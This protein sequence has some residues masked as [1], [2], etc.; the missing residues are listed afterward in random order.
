MFSIIAQAFVKVV[1]KGMCNEGV[2]RESPGSGS[3]KGC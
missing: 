1:H 3:D 2:E